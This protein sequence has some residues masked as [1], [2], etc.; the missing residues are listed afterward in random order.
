MS[1]Q[2]T[3]PSEPPEY[4]KLREVINEI[5]PMGLIINETRINQYRP[6]IKTI[7]EILP[8]IES[9]EQLTISIQTIFMSWF[10]EDIS[11]QDNAHFKIAEIIW[12][13]KDEYGML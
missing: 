12:N 6:I 10:M 1:I 7:L 11:K 13:A 3:I 2:D 8:T 9:L 4:F 5:N